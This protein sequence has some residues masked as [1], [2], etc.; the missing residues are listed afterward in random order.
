MLAGGLKIVSE[1]DWQS[2]TRI[3][4]H[5][6][7]APCHG[8]KYHDT[9]T[10]DEFP[11]GDPNGIIIEEMLDKL[12]QSQVEYYFG[13]LKS[14]TDKMIE[15]FNEHF[16]SLSCPPEGGKTTG[17]ASLQV[18]E[19]VG[20]G[21]KVSL[22]LSLSEDE[23]EDDDEKETDSITADYDTEEETDQ[24][25]LEADVVAAAAGPYV[26][27]IDIHDPSLLLSTITGKVSITLTLQHTP[28]TTP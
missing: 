24:F 18:E 8:R 16:A 10:P 26:K 28:V 14:H 11:D 17:D 15:V 7:D 3:L 27:A 1:L 6:G 13:R 4:F 5:I 20:G 9:R 19:L 22:G 2:T 12:Y 21:A 25:D 23:D